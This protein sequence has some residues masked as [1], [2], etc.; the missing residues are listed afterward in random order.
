MILACFDEFALQLLG[1]FSIQID[2]LHNLFQLTF[3]LILH[4]DNAA[5]ALQGQILHQDRNQLLRGF[6]FV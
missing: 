2:K 6:R 3:L 4:N 1:L 5:S